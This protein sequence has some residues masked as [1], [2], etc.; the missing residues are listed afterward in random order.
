MNKVEADVTGIRFLNSVKSITN[1][2]PANPESG[3]RYLVSGS[4]HKNFVVEYVDQQWVRDSLYPYTGVVVEEEGASYTY[5]KHSSHKF[6]WFKSLTVDSIA[7][8]YGRPHKLIQIQDIVD[9]SKGLY[10]CDGRLQLKLSD[11]NCLSFE[12]PE[13]TDASLK[14]NF[15]EDMFT[16][17][18]SKLTIKKAYYTANEI[19]EK[20]SAVRESFGSVLNNFVD[21]I[22]S[23]K[24]EI[25]SI[26]KDFTADLNALLTGEKLVEMS[27]IIQE[28]TDDITFDGLFFINKIQQA[29]SFNI[30][31]AVKVI[32]IYVDDCLLQFGT[33][34]MSS[35]YVVTNSNE[36]SQNTKILF[37]DTLPVGSIVRLEAILELF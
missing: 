30:E 12:D 3:D 1:S 7:K 16:I 33:V 6:K 11:S 13:S 19:D 2:L 21:E 10:V 31:D 37:A 15:D 22:K 20:L 5:S 32:K 14:L 27:F 23:L 8:I 24:L 17:L 9:M 35:D 4:T 26:R 29:P 28:P 36:D 25:K 18:D 34:R